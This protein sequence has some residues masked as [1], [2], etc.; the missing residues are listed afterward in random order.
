MIYVDDIITFLILGIVAFVIPGIF[1]IWNIYNCFSNIPRREKLISSITVLLGG[2]FYLLL[3]VISFEEAGDWYVQVNTAQYHYAISSKYCG[4]YE[5]IVLL[6]FIGYFVLVFFPANKLPPLVSAISIS[7]VILLNVLQI[8]YAIQIAKNVD[9]I[10]LLLYVYHFNILLLSARVIYLHMIQQIEIFK[11]RTAEMEGHK[12]FKRFYDYINNLSKY[13]FFLFVILFFV[14]AVIEIIFVIAG[15]G[16]DAPI[17]AF[18]ETADW[19]FSKQIPPPPLEYKGHYL[20]TVAAGGH[21]RVVKPLRFGTRRGE[22]IIVNRQLCIANA[23]EEMI[24]ERLPVFHK[25]IRYAYDTYGYPLSKN[26]TSPIKA[27]TVYFVMKPLEWF[28]LLCLY[29]L[30][31]R[32]EQRISNQY[33][34]SE[35]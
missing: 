18:T 1:T 3:F 29:M 11:E 15:Q 20:C 35:H 33:I 2:F 14:I 26:I 13:S 16:I 25:K 5:G 12:G 32:P 28:F 19:T 23:F 17:K 10:E 34:W 24:Q 7:M 4:I 21:K 31:T 30:D 8:V 22:T 9:G 6:G 27:D